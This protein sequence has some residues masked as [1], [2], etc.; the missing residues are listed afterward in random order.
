MKSIVLA[1]LLLCSA[2]LPAQNVITF[3]K[4]KN[5]KTFDVTVPEVCILKLKNGKRYRTV[6]I[7]KEDSVLTF[8][9]SADGKYKVASK[10]QVK[11]VKKNKA[12]NKREKRV[13]LT[14]LML[15]DTTKFD[16]SA[17]HRLRFKRSYKKGGAFVVI[18]GA[19]LQAVGTYFLVSSTMGY[20]YEV[21]LRVHPLIGGAIFAGCTYGFFFSIQRDIYTKKWKLKAK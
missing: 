7:N 16:Y 1:S 17:I 6:L 21:P 20:D 11:S 15:S 13:A 18:G 5:Q 10:G 12:L 3:E 19:V 14:T 2:L 8:S 4:N 9:F